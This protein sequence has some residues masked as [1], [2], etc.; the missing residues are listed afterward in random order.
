MALDSYRELIDELAT[1]P[2][3]IIEAANAAGDPPAG[4]WSANEVVS[5][6]AAC[7]EAYLE[8][9]S[10]ILTK[11]QPALHPF[12]KRAQTRMQELLNNDLASNLAY[13]GEQR[14]ELVSQLMSMTLGDWDRK[15]LHP[16][17]GTV[18]IEEMVE[19]ILDHDADHLEQL[20]ALG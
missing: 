6:L 14:G 3:E 20:K 17:E 8:R 4:G 10:T 13:F 7:E 11:Q 16:T 18:S 9:V 12:D 1:A 19:N 5:H 2:Q 15:G